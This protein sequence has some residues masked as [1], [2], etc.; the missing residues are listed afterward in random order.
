MKSFLMFAAI[1]M[2]SSC[3]NQFKLSIEK[4]NAYPGTEVVGRVMDFQTK[5]LSGSRVQISWHSEYN[6]DQGE[7][8]VMRKTGMG[9]FEKIGIVKP[10]PSSGIVDYA[11]TDI[12]NSEDSSFYSIMQVDSKGVKYFSPATG[13][14]GIKKADNL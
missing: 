14:K 2:G 6:K 4:S 12:N 5:R 8:T 1:L 13:V 10:K 3:Q 11:L 7:F 9:I